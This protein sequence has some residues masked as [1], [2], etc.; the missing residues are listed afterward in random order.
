MGLLTVSK[1]LEKDHPEII[2][3]AIRWLEKECNAKILN[4]DKGV[5]TQYY[6]EGDAIPKGEEKFDVIFKKIVPQVY[7]ITI[8]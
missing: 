5:N 7:S 6:V 1:K 8:R 3:M 4:I 2:L